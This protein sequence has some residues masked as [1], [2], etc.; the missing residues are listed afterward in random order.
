MV[1]ETD[2]LLSTNT[3]YHS[4]ANAE[5]DDL[6]SVHE[7]QEPTSNDEDHCS[8]HEANMKNLGDISLSLLTLCLCVG[9]FLA[10][11]DS[12]I[13]ATIFNV[14]GTEFKS[15]NLAIWVITSYLLSASALQPMYAKL[16]DIFGR[17]TTLVFVLTFFLVGSFGCGA[18]QNMVQLGIA[19]AIA[20]CG[21]AGLFVMSSV[22]I[23][24]LVPM[25]QRGQYQ[26]YINM[27]QTIGSTVG[28]P[29]GGIIND[30]FGWRHC[31]YLNVPPC[32][33]IL[34][35][36]VYRLENY[37]LSKSEDHWSHNL[38]SK[39]KN[40]DY[41]GALLLLIANTTF[42]VAASFGGNTHEWTDPLIIILLALS[43]LFF[44]LFGLNEMYWAENPL[45]SRS[46]IKNRNVVA[47]CLNNFF[48]CNSTM[49]MNFLVPQFFMGVL[50]YP[51][52]S[53]GLWVL[54]RTVCVAL[55]C[56]TA[57][58]YLAIKG[59]YYHYLVIV[60]IFQTAAAICTYEWTPE[61]PMWIKV[62]AMNA[63]GYAFGSVFVAT[64]VA[65]VA[66]IDHKETASATSMLFL[67]RSTGWLTGGSLSAAILQANLKN[68]LVKSITGP[69]ADKIIEFVRT[70]ITKIRT[71]S[72]ELQIVVLKAL[73]EA[74]HSSLFYAVVTSAICFVMTCLFKDCNLLRKRT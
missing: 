47:V 31:F 6:V 10:S 9:A 24:D 39:F 35:I 8:Y 44:V 56:W 17:K 51:T 36:Y 14:I 38:S 62:V 61:T 50:G 52:S 20:G 48:L 34:Y 16:S 26:S 49:T 30:M 55:G 60:M 11:L 41:Y 46:L 12:S 42:V 65:L 33:F 23:H 19:R 27:A 69:E 18:A 45:I 29:L 3:N 54:P 63:E 71:L 57:G 72:P 25:K 2:R 40:I 13:V 1:K 67:C 73:Q 53:A 64:M 22:A 15:A 28:A 21:G 58:R 7:H 5:N 70:S 59:K 43:P 32:L 66:D 4:L 68:N 37:N 74:I